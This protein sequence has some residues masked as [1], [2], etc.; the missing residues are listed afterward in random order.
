MRT[1]ITAISVAVPLALA[2]SSG[3]AQ[4]SDFMSK[5]Q[6]MLGQGQGDQAVKEAYQQ[7]WRDAMRQQANQR[8][9]RDRDYNSNSD[10]RYNRPGDSGYSGN[11]SRY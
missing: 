10:N 7:G 3:Y 9:N 8:N 5:A 6:S 11:G 1:L 4:S 2:T